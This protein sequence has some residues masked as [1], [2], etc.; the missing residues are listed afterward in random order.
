VTGP[1]RPAGRAGHPD[2]ACLQAREDA[3]VA[4][5]SRREQDPAVLTHL[6]GCPPCHQEYLELA[7]LSDLLEAA[8][9][10]PPV[11]AP[12]PGTLL[13]DRL[14]LQVGQRRR[15]RR[16]ATAMA[17]AAAVVAVALPLARLAADRDAP[18]PAR[19]GGASLS[20]SPSSATPYTDAPWGSAGG[21]PVYAEGSGSDSGTGAGVDVS[22]A[23]RGSGSTLLV[24]VRGVPTGQHCRLIVHDAAG[25]AVP[26]GGWTVS[27]Q[28]G[29]PYTETVQ[30]APSAVRQVELVDDRTGRRLVEVA[31]RRV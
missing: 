1:D 2:P 19:A 14:L 8:R 4:L 11:P 15:R 26:A 6:R 24:A 12:P 23:G 17:A 28:Y 3:A 10:G 13:L 9:G 20:A 31:V 21:G 7:A 16:M 5:L 25:H 29:A 30:V 22:V 27:G 18:G